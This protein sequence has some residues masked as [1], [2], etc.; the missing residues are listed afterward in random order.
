[1]IETLVCKRMQAKQNSTSPCL[2]KEEKRKRKGNRS[3]TLVFSANIHLEMNLLQTQLPV[4]D[5]E[6]DRGLRI[7]SPGQGAAVATFPGTNKLNSICLDLK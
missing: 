6:C 1:M 3:P 4:C 2:G 7:C 5:S